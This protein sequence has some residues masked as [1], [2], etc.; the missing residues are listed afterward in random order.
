MAQCLKYLGCKQENL[1]SSPSCHITLEHS[2]AL[3]SSQSTEK[4]QGVFKSCFRK[5]NQLASSAHVS[6]TLFKE[7]NTML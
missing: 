6:E 5:N 7:D 3:T 4:R 2:G 1:N